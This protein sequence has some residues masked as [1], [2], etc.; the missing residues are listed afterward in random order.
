MLDA[1]PEENARKRNE[2]EQ[3]IEKVKLHSQPFVVTLLLSGT[4][5]GRVTRLKESRLTNGYISQ[6]VFYRTDG[7]KLSNAHLAFQQ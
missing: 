7:I 6:R 1:N 5:F 3:V 2:V 4:G